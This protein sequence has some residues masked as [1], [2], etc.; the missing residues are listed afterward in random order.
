MSETA[1]RLNGSTAQRTSLALPP[2]VRC[3]GPCNRWSHPNEIVPIGPH[4]GICWQCY[5]RHHAALRLL[6]GYA[7][8]EEC[9]NCHA[10]AIELKLRELDGELRFYVHALDQ[11][12][13][14]LCRQCSD[15]VVQLTPER[16]KGTPYGK[17]HQIQ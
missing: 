11:I 13:V 15:H 8:P 12:Y 16:Y 9:P 5:E 6:Q 1:Q 4:V 17:Q 2:A 10:S 3:Q 14:L 7:P